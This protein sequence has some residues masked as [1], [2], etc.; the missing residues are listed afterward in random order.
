MVLRNANKAKPDA[1]D[2][3]RVDTSTMAWVAALE[4]CRGVAWVGVCKVAVCKVAVCKVVACKVVACKVVG[5][6]REAAWG[7]C[8]EVAWEV[9]VACRY[10]FAESF[11]CSVCMSCLALRAHFA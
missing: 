9:L 10:T 4:E 6:C 3:Y 8:K 2:A 11:L 1:S 5:V 7:A